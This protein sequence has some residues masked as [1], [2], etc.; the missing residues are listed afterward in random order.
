MGRGVPHLAKLGDPIQLTVERGYSHPVPMGGTPM[1]PMGGTSSFPMV[2]Y[3]HQVDGEISHSSQQ[4]YPDLADRGY[5]GVP[6]LGLDGG[7]TRWYWM[8]VRPIGTG[9]GYPVPPSGVRAVIE[10]LLCGGWYVSCVHA[11]G[12][13]CFLKS[14][15]VLVINM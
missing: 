8:E 11:G 7:T 2:G 5:P 10:H 3:P 9:W 6:L 12:F 15:Y 1:W 4:G 13:S 14:V